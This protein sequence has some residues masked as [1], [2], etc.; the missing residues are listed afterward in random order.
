[1]IWSLLALVCLLYLIVLTGRVIFDVV[2]MVSR[3]FRPKGILLILAEIFYSLT[4][5]PVKFLRR[6]IPPLTLG[7]VRIDIGFLILFVG[8]SF[9]LRLFN[10]LAAS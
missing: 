9:L 8:V 5:P 1:M 6:H 10:I 2:Q 7:Q 4:D 3:D